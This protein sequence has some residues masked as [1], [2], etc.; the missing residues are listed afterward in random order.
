MSSNHNHNDENDEPSTTAYNNNNSMVPQALDAPLLDDYLSKLLLPKLSAVLSNSTQDSKIISNEFQLALLQMVAILWT[1]GHTPSL[2]TLQ[3]KLT[4]LNEG[5][6]QPYTTT[7]SFNRILWY[8]VL[9]VALPTLYDSAKQRW[10]AYVA[11]ETLR[12]RFEAAASATTSTRPTQTQTQRQLLM[13]QRRRLAI[14]TLFRVVDT[15][16]P[17]LR[18]GCLLSVWRRRPL[19]N[20]NHQHLAPTLA[21][22]LLGLHYAATS[23]TSA[24]TNSVPLLQVYYAHRRWLHDEVTRLLPL[25]LVPLQCAWSESTD[26]V[27]S[28]F[29][30][31]FIYYV[32]V[33]CEVCWFFLF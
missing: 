4:D 14:S 32:Y 33:V 6:R 12:E 16:V 19:N 8:A 13:Q 22:K 31:V 17:M 3:M 27:Q 15:I 21:M 24:S 30:Y 25:V 9:S 28:W 1:R 11:Q 2:Q 7:N 18:L 20:N 26:Y 29:R 5:R 10:T 23:T